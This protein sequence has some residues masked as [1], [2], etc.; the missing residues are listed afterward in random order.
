MINIIYLPIVYLDYSFEDSLVLIT[1]RE[2]RRIRDK[3]E[4]SKWLR[5]WQAINFVASDQFKY[6]KTFVV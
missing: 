4:K 6:F 5:I 2:L 3:R 1:I